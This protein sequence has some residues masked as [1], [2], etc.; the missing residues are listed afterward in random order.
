MVCAESTAVLGEHSAAN[1]RKQQ[2]LS[3]K[4]YRDLKIRN[5][6]PQSPRS[7]I[8]LDTRVFRLLE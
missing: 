1:C 7:C 8:N 2:D 6:V 5:S 4:Y 3:Q